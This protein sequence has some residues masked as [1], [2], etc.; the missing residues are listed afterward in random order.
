[1][2]AQSGSMRQILD[3]PT[4]PDSN[5]TSTCGFF[6]WKGRCA[7]RFQNLPHTSVRR[8]Q[9]CGEKP[10]S[11]DQTPVLGI[12]DLRFCWQKSSCAR[13]FSIFPALPK[14][15]ALHR[16]LQQHWR[17]LRQHPLVAET[18]KGRCRKTGQRPFF[19]SASRRVHGD[20]I[21]KNILP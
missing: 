11:G 18:S 21:T 4:M 13:R 7:R 14:Y 17:H 19:V 12:H 3:M 2:S 8:F 9:K 5:N 20:C 16:E 10:R 1:M 15:K 6:S